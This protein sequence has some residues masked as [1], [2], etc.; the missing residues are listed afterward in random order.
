MFHLWSSMFDALNLFEIL[1]PKGQV[2]GEHYKPSHFATFMSFKPRW[3]VE[4]S[5]I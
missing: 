5:P 2:V 3:Q 1:D 4:N